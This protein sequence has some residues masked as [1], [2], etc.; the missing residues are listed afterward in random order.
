MAAAATCALIAIQGAYLAVLAGTWVSASV[1]AAVYARIAHRPTMGSL[2]V[3]FAFLASLL[4]I[5]GLLV[6]G[7][8]LFVW[9]RTPW[10]VGLALAFEVVWL[11]GHAASLFGAFQWTSIVNL[12]AATA[13]VAGL[14]VDSSRQVPQP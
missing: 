3:G 2:A 12:V 5:V 10:A 6:I 1:A 7:L 14:L 4:V 11:V 13:I 8:A 9:R